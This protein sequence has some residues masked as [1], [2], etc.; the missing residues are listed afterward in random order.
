VKKY[1]PPPGW[2]VQA[3]RFGLDPTP[4]QARNLVSHCGAARFAYNWAVSWVRA[5]WDQRTAELS[6][7][8]PEEELTPWRPWS[9]PSLRKVWNQVKDELAPWWQ[10]HSKEAYNTGLAGGATAFGN[11]VAS[12]NG[13]RAGRGVGKPR[14]KRKHTAA[15]SCRFTTGTIRVEPD[16][17]HVT[18]PRL[19]TVKTHE[20]TRKL[21][22]R[23]AAGTARILSATVSF[24]C[25]RWFCSFQVEAKRADPAGARRDTVIG[26][27]LGIPHLAVLSSP[28][29]GVSD[30]NG[31]VA[32]PR[33]LAATRKRV[34]HASRRVS[35]RQGPDRR[36]GQPPSKR[37]RKASR[38]RNRLHHR[39][40]SLR[41]DGLHKL[42][43]ALVGYADTLVVEDLNV[44]GMLRNKRLARHIADAGWGTLRRMLEYKTKWDGGTLQVADRWF[45][46]S[47]TCSNCGMTKT[48][49]PLRIRIFACEHCGMVVDRD[50]NAARNLAQ[51]V[52]RLDESGTGVAGDPR[53]SGW[54]GRGADRR[55]R[56][57]LAGGCEAF[58]PQR[59]GA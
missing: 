58:T 46:S 4:R 51:L 57:G 17:T 9:L 41:A 10:E 37:W 52:T 33:Y 1:T 55:T 12:G 42:T 25:G 30:T 8:L 54:N 28:V 50:L 40:A 6:Y 39:V 23:L 15:L 13:A 22:R 11:Y 5:A 36:T 26:I 2:T 48:K 18:L 45:P 31:F 27:D 43:T 16:R 20:S 47:K 29:P 19:G 34:S 14:R 49:L 44:A 24:R 38:Q 35:R 32:N 3:Y 56:L 21:A 53:P 59:L 7:G